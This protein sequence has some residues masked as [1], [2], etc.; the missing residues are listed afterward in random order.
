MAADLAPVLPPG[1]LVLLAYDF[2]SDPERL[3]ALRRTL[4][5]L[6]GVQEGASASRLV[7]RL[8]ASS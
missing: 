2:T 4:P 6:E 5:G 8:L 7:R 1:I 3:E